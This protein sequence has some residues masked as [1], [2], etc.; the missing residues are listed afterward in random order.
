MYSGDIR[1][2]FTL[3][4]AHTR[5]SDAIE[6]QSIQV[7]EMRLR[8]TSLGFALCLEGNRRDVLE[9]SR[10]RQSG[11]RLSPHAFRFRFAWSI[12]DNSGKFG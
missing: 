7:G 6:N 9:S 8:Q 4:L 2:P 3:R 11:K 1:G 12:N 10:T 5:E